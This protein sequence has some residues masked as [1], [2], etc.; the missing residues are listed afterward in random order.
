MDRS[1][2]LPDRCIYCNA[3][4]NG[5][6]LPQ[7]LYWSPAAWRICAVA[8]PFVAAGIGIATGTMVLVALF[9]PL[10]LLLMVV[11][12]FVR[13]KVELD[14]AF[15]ARHR[16]LRSALRWASGACVVAMLASIPLWNTASNVA[17]G[18]FWTALIGMVSVVIAQSVLGLRALSLSKLNAEHVWLARTGNPF[19]AALP[20]LK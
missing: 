15:C 6:R 3:G 7:K 4:A 18:I 11:H 2:A 20:E 16:Q 17:A 10:V 9:W 1:G 12:A 5:Y 8:L 13:T 19:R 14:I